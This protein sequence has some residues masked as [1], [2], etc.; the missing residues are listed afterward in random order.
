M[1]KKVTLRFHSKRYG[2]L[3][4]KEVELSYQ[5]WKPEVMRWLWPALERFEKDTELDSAHLTVWDVLSH[6]LPGLAHVPSWNA[7]TKIPIEELEMEDVRDLYMDIDDAFHKLWG[8]DRGAL[9]SGA[10]RKFL[11]AHLQERRPDG[12]VIRASMGFR[13]KGRANHTPRP[14]ISDQVR[15]EDGEAKDAPLGAMPHRNP[16]NLKV[17]QKQRMQADLQMISD[18]CCSELDAYYKACAVQDEI[19]A[20]DWDQE[21]TLSVLRKLPYHRV[22]ETMQS[23]GPDERRALIA[24]YLKIDNKPETPLEVAPL[25]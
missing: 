6:G 9:R 3:T 23:L 1:E 11:T 14:L 12:V 15:C 5:D 19:L 21:F 24:H 7:F 8:A 17:L 18:A 16:A 10:V 22:V 25:V 4:F 13:P 20:E 2:R